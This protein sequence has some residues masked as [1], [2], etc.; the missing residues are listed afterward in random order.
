MEEKIYVFW[1][2][3][4]INHWKDIA[5][6]QY[7]TMESS[8]LLDRAEQVNVTFLGKDRSEI[9]WLEDKS[10]KI[11]VNNYSPNILHYERMCLNGLRDWSEQN[12]G[13]VLYIHG[14]GVSR[15]R[16]KRNV[17]GWR[18][19]LEYFN[20]ENHDRCTEEIKCLD[21]LGGN[22]C[23][24]KNRS[25]E[26]PGHCMHYSGNFW[27]SRASHVR[28]LPRIP[29]DIRME[30]HGNYIKYCEYWLLQNFPNIR[31]GVA[32]KT[33]APHYY[34]FPPEP[35]FRKKWCDRQTT[36]TLFNSY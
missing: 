5:A 22:V 10:K 14:K 16:Q 32:F 13:L 26:V 25:L 23:V 27:W 17:W 21:V 19:M 24:A 18:K 4:G 33:K 28:K 7:K 20:V 3:C 15:T 30:I 35:D 1:H 9:V 34:E 6:D 29:E 11:N 31:C 12:N 2:I 8:E 36:T